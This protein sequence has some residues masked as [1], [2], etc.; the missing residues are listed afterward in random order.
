MGHLGYADVV[1][2]CLP[3]AQ[4]NPKEPNVDVTL[5]LLL[6]ASDPILTLRWLLL[7]VGAMLASWSFVRSRYEQRPAI[8]MAAFSGVLHGGVHI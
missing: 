8:A 4:A 7:S 6:H 5:V 1:A 2:C 3:D